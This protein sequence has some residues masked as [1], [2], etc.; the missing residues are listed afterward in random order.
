MFELKPGGSR[1]PGKIVL[2]WEA[3]KNSF[4]LAYWILDGCT[5]RGP[6]IFGDK[7]FL[8][9]IQKRKMQFFDCTKTRLG[10]L[11]ITRSGCGID[12]LDGSMSTSLA[13][14]HSV[15]YV[16]HIAR[17]KVDQGWTIVLVDKIV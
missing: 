10:R 3:P 16:R 13:Q 5:T 4:A 14:V 11:V 1:T 7:Y 17:P 12:L 9:L 2:W 6:T 8:A 15:D